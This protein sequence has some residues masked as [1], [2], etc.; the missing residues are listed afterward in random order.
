MIQKRTKRSRSTWNGLIALSIVLRRRRRRS[1]GVG[2]AGRRSR[3]RQADHRLMLMLVLRWKRWRVVGNTLEGAILRR[4]VILLMLDVV[5]F[6]WNWDSFVFLF[7]AHVDLVGSNTIF[8]DWFGFRLD[9]DLFFFSSF[10]FGVWWRGSCEMIDTS[11][12]DITTVG[13]LNV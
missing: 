5:V 7:L 4:R 1:W 9:W 6:S 3:L 11:L 8:L 2:G 10:G 13:W 12:I